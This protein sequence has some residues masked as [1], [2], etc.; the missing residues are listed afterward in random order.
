MQEVVHVPGL[1][2]D[3]QVVVRTVVPIHHLPHV[4]VGARL[5]MLTDPDGSDVAIIDWAKVPPPNVS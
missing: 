2:A 3:H 5:P 4:I 1:V